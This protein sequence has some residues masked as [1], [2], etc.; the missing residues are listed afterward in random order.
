MRPVIDI[1]DPLFLQQIRTQ[2]I[3]L[4]GGLCQCEIRWRDFVEPIPLKIWKGQ[5]PGEAP[6]ILGA[7]DHIRLEIHVLNLGKKG[8]LLSHRGGL[9]GTI[10]HE[11]AHHLVNLGAMNDVGDWYYTDSHDQQDA[12]FDKWAPT[13]GDFYVASKAKEMTA[14]V[15]RVISGYASSEEWEANKTFLEEYKNFLQGNEVFKHFLP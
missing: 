4:E 9:E 14:E 10:L 13:L 15:F 6:N 12:L 11:F 2:A 1:N 8:N 5:I 3:P 7:Y